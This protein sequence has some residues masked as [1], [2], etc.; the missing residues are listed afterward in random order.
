MSRLLMSRV[1][2]R[3]GRALPRGSTL[4]AIAM[5]FRGLRV[6]VNLYLFVVVEK[7]W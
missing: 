1:R 5:P 6:A 7:A 3:D 4:D 2:S